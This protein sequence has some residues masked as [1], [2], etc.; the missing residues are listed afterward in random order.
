MNFLAHIFLSGSDEDLLI[1]NYIGDYVKGNEFNNYQISIR[2]GIILHRK[3]DTFTDT[4]PIVKSDKKLF[5]SVYHKYSGIITDIIYDHYLALEWDI[6]SNIPFVDFKNNIYDLLIYRIN[7]M[8]TEIQ[9]IV[10]KFVK[11]D[12]LG[13]YQNLEG[14]E[15]VLIGMSKAT[16]LPDESEYAMSTF[17]LHYEE[18]RHHFNQFFPMLIDYVAYE[19]E[20]LKKSDPLKPIN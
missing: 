5:S 6:Y 16:S 14:I 4:H 13:S 12:W 19:N 3:I 20:K 1:G 2:R 15:S 18:I 17:R 8:P 10:P 7:E 11:N 9:S